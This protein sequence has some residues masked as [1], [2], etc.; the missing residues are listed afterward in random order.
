MLVTYIDPPEGWRHGFPKAIPDDIM[1]GIGSIKS[2]LLE[3]GYPKTVMD[4]YGAHFFYRTWR[5]EINPNEL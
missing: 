4:N 2:W 1:Q 3:Q 5:E